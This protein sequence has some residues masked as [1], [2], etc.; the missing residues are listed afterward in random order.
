MKNCYTDAPPDPPMKAQQTRGSN[1]SA[2]HEVQNEQNLVTPLL[3]KG[4]AAFAYTRLLVPAYVLVD[5]FV[6][7]SAYFNFD[8]NS[9]SKVLL[10]TVL[11]IATILK[12]A[13]TLTS[14]DGPIDAALAALMGQKAELLL[15]MVEAYRSPFMPP[16]DKEEAYKAI[17]ALFDRFN[18]DR[19]DMWESMNRAKDPRHW[20]GKMVAVVE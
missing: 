8:G 11:Q 6:Q 10:V 14:A 13:A 9:D 3:E 1:A 17:H 5:E 15:E 19:L 12:N 20:A 18:R 2:V 7:V 4:Y 16:T